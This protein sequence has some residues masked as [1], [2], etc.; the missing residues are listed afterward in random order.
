MPSTNLPPDALAAALAA[1]AKTPPPDMAGGGGG[2]GAAPPSAPSQ[3]TADPNAA[4]G[5]QDPNATDPQTQAVWDA[6]PS[7]D[8]QSAQSLLSTMQGASPDQLVQMLGSFMQQAEQDQTKLSQMQEA[9]VAHMMELL[10]GPGGAP[11]A[12]PGAAPIPA[13]GPG[14]SGA[15]GGGTPY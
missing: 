13:A 14:V 7:T 2:G 6:F 11:Q 12:Q 9:I 8:P 3:D 4:Q 15:Q 1:A 5:Q 10:G